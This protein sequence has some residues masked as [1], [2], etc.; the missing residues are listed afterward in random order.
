[1][2]SRMFYS[3]AKFNWPAMLICFVFVLIGIWMI[4]DGTGSGWLVIGFFA[5]GLIAEI[6]SSLP[7]LNWLLLEPERFQIR[8]LHVVTGVTWSEVS[9]FFLTVDGQT[10]VYELFSEPGETSEDP[11]EYFGHLPDCYGLSPQ[12]LLELLNL[13]KQS[14]QAVQ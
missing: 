12:A 2:G 7:Q 14:L 11:N 9:R 3:K 5:L 8:Q 6:A 10:V 1:M 4:R 13:Y